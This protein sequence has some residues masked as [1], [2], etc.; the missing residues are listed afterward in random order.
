MRKVGVGFA[1]ARWEGEG[2]SMVAV[3]ESYDFLSTG[4]SYRSS[5]SHGVGF[6]TRVSEAHEFDSRRREALCDLQ[7]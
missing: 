5:K 2:A 6:G 4:V 1:E 7:N 3:L